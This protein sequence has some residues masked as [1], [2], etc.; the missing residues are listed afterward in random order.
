M[1]GAR[2]L[3]ARGLLHNP[4]GGPLDEARLREALSS[5]RR[6]SRVDGF[7]IYPDAALTSLRV[8]EVFTNAKRVRDGGKRIRDYEGVSRFRALTNL[9]IARCSGASGSR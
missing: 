3:R 9:G 1:S 8:P 2:R 4:K 7:G 5:A 6:T